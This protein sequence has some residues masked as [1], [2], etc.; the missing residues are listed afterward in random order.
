M[1]V[2]MCTRHQWYDVTDESASPVVA[3]IGHWPGVRLMQIGSTYTC[4]SCQ[5]EVT[6]EAASGEAAM[7]RWKGRSG[8]R[9]RKQVIG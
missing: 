8:D 3:M 9:L 2:C 7:V 5:V 1:T 4:G 6:I